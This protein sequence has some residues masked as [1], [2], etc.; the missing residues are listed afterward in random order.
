[1]IKLT[2]LLLEMVMFDNWVTPKQDVLR[3][4]FEV[5]HEKKGLDYFD[6]ASDFI[7]AVHRAKVVTVTPSL[8]AKIENRSGTKT[9][10]ELLNLIKGYK[11]YPKYR[12]EKTLD[13]I[14]DGFKNNTPMEYPLVLQF[15][16]GT[17]RILAG[18]TRMDI[19]FQSKIMPKVLMIPI[20]E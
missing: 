8:D 18:N 11:S 10:K 16:D 4:E 9:K 20:T 5:E 2:N 19:A 3:R 6:T 17:Y 12:N 7:D 1:M 13:I 14:Y 15:N